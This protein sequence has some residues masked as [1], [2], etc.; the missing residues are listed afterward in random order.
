MGKLTRCKRGTR[1]NKKTGNCEGHHPLNMTKYFEMVKLLLETGKIYYANLDTSEEEVEE[2]PNELMRVHLSNAFQI[3][4]NMNNMKLDV[5][6][7]INQTAN[8]AFLQKL[9][10]SVVFSQKQLDRVNSEIKKWFKE[11]ADEPLLIS[12]DATVYY[13]AIK[14]NLYMFHSKFLA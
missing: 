1:R 3:F 4:V 12:E 8:R 9:A 11:D 5:L 13:L 14:E 10:N 2:P 6:Q 7:Q